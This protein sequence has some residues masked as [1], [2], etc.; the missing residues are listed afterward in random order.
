[1]LRRVAKHFKTFLSII[2]IVKRQK[3]ERDLQNP[4]VWSK[5]GFLLLPFLELIL[6]GKLE[7]NILDSM[8]TGVTRLTKESSTMTTISLYL[9][10]DG[11]QNLMLPLAMTNGRDM[12]LIQMTPAMFKW[13]WT[14]ISA[15]HTKTTDFMQNVWMKWWTSLNTNETLILEE[16]TESAINSKS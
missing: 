7:K 10:K 16:L 6:L 13:C 3:K 8:A 4:D 15:L 14:L 5:D 9:L 11:H 1:M 12:T 2:S